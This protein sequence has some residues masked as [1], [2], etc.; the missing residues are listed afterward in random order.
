MISKIRVRNDVGQLT[1]ALAAVLVIAGC[2]A[3]TPPPAI[4]TASG[5]AA[6]ATVSDK[7]AS[8]KATEFLDSITVDLSDRGDAEVAEIARVTHVT[9][10]DGN[11]Q[12][13]AITTPEIKAAAGEE[14]AA[15][16]VETL[17]GSFTYDPAQKVLR[18]SGEYVYWVS[19]SRTPLGLEDKEDVKRLGRPQKNQVKE[20]LVG[21]PCS[22]GWL[23]RTGAGKWASVYSTGDKRE[24]PWVMNIRDFGSVPVMRNQGTGVGC[25]P[26]E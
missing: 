24:S 20:G 12:S 10:A 5:S 17:S 16:G 23:I 25:V 14:L 2:S 18:A 7:P 4:N 8:S 22:P 26:A 1:V 9:W 6:T 11:Y 15:L 3:T 21:A 19:A 13:P